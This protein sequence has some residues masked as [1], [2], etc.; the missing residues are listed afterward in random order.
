MPGPENKHG[1]LA[2]VAAILGIV[3]T[4]AVFVGVFLLVI[5]R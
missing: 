4:L 5:P 3:V 2:V 1:R